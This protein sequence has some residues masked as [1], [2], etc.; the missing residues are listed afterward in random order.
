MTWYAT[1]ILA[2]C[3]DKLLDYVTR[4]PQLAAHAYL[5][6]EPIEYRIYKNDEIF[7]PPPSGLLVIRPI[8][9]PDSHCAEWHN[10]SLISWHALQATTNISTI[11]LASF[12]D[13][14]QEEIIGEFP[15]TSFF[16]WLKQVAAETDSDLAF[17][18][19]FMW[20]G[21]TEYEYVWLFGSREEAS[22]VLQPR[23]TSTVARVDKKSEVKQF[24]LDLLS[25]TLAYLG[26]P[27]PATFWL[28]HFR[29]FVWSDYKIVSDEI[30]G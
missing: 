18:R 4:H 29:G 3:N 2:R 15:P 13:H 16:R 14:L 17:F 26:A 5:I 27:I 28:P 25:D 20:G 23:Y 6:R 19:S 11:E 10:S 1:E 21:D 22:L 7:T 30:S 12:G 8:C 24:E 9:E